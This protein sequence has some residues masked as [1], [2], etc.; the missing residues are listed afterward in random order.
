MLLTPHPSTHTDA[1]WQRGNA[2]NF[3]AWTAAGQAVAKTR[4]K[5]RSVL[6][7]WIAQKRFLRVDE[8]G[9]VVSEDSGHEQLVGMNAL[10]AD[11][12]GDS[13]DNTPLPQISNPDYGFFEDGEMTAYTNPHTGLIG[14]FYRLAS[15][16]LERSQSF[17]T[18]EQEVVSTKLDSLAERMLQMPLA[19]TRENVTALCQH[20]IELLALL[21]YQ[22]EV[23]QWRRLNGMLS[24]IASALTLNVPELPAS[25]AWLSFTAAL[26]SR[27]SFEN[28][29]IMRQEQNRR[30]AEFVEQQIAE[31]WEELPFSNYKGYE[32]GGFG[33]CLFLSISYCLGMQPH[34]GQGSISDM[35]K[36]KNAHE[37]RQYVVNYMQDQSNPAASE[38][39][40]IWRDKVVLS[41]SNRLMTFINQDCNELWQEKSR[42]SAVAFLQG[43]ERLSLYPY[44]DENQEDA[45]RRKNAIF[46]QWCTTMKRSLYQM[47]FQLRKAYEKRD[48]N[49]RFNDSVV[50]VLRGVEG[51]QDVYIG[52]PMQMDVFLKDWLFG[53]VT[54]ADSKSPYGD[55]TVVEAASRRYNARFNVYEPKYNEQLF[56]RITSYGQLSKRPWYALA[57]L[58]RN[59]Y[60]PIVINSGELR[61]APLGIDGVNGPGIPRPRENYDG[62]VPLV[63]PYDEEDENSDAAK[64]ARENAPRELEQLAA[65]QQKNEQRLRAYQEEQARLKLARERERQ[66]A[67]EQAAEQAAAAR[68]AAQR[69]AAERAAAQRA[70]AERAADQEQARR[71]AEAARN[72][73]EE[74]RREAERASKDL[75][76]KNLRDKLARLSNLFN[77]GSAPNRAD[78]LRKFQEDFLEKLTRRV[79]E[80][81][82]P[83][84]PPR[85]PSPTPPEEPA[86]PPLLRPD[87]QL[88]PEDLA[89]RN[90]LRD[91]NRKLQRL[92]DERG[93]DIPDICFLKDKD[94]PDE[95]RDNPDLVVLRAQLCT[96]FYRML[97]KD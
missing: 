64:Q 12:V 59:H 40:K 96:I 19:M 42:M 49:S 71:D 62:V 47:Y 22:T 11:P 53:R 23:R 14:Q 77:P 55:E 56:K 90:K 51:W 41:L 80:Q 94:L 34:G 84:L 2:D 58:G 25:A 3:K 17:F 86:P 88:S 54:N 36:W 52:N 29:E 13:S 82:P 5:V 9:G 50:P 81:T 91:F 15:K 76:D 93:G 74:A 31:R 24:Q 67:A 18:D 21:V 87:D 72:A 33:E 69:D 38:R 28:E 65:A 26:R 1:F 66:R 16:T 35:Q 20:L 97:P 83:P 75:R 73:A 63:P 61:E 70:A 39:Y 4:Q 8:E 44:P 78:R 43:Q 6:E 48:T 95:Y 79:Y 92:N 60:Q 57:Y 45:E 46:E 7:K 10:F 68:A 30:Q 89:A 32:L 37:V 27:T 85:S